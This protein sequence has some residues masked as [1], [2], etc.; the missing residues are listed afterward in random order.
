MEEGLQEIKQKLEEATLELEKCNAEKQEFLDGWQRAKA[1][2]VNL[3]KRSEEEK[4]LLLDL[5]KTGFISEVLPVL[6]SL[7]SALAHNEPDA[8]A[9]R[10]GIENT[11]N[12]FVSILKTHEI[13]QYSPQVGDEFDPVRNICVQTVPVAG[14]ESLNKILAILG[15]GYEIKG[16]VIRP[17]LVTVGVEEESPSQTN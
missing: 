17:A 7:D 10:K 1:D 11:Y 9:W 8:V 2:Y 6:D 16:K 14:K 4:A 5:A 3:K 12:S 13:E 15:K